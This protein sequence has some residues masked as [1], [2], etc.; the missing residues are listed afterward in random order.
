MI[1]FLFVHSLFRWLVILSILF[2]ILVSLVAYQRDLKFNK[3]ANLLRHWTAT[4]A[5][6]QLVIGMLLAFK[7][8]YFIYFWQNMEIAWGNSQSV[9]YGLIHPLLMLTSI[10]ILTVGSAKSKRKAKDRDKFKTMLVWYSI[11]AILIFIAIPWPFSP[12]AN[13]PLIPH[14]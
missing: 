9:F 4:I 13:R 1:I 2:S 14:F 5:H 12:L 6:I 10:V 3:K 11:A 7:S 8:P